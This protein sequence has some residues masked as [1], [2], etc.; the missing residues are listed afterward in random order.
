M[1]T[2]LVI[3][4]KNSILS[5]ML[6]RVS[7]ILRDNL[8]FEQFNQISI[9][10]HFFPDKWDHDIPQRPSNPTLY[11]DLS[12]RDNATR[13]PSGIKR[14]MDIIGSALILVICAPVFLIIALAIKAIVERPGVL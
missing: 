14:M 6:S 7:N 4:D 9:S 11:P 5:T 1:F 13:L 10:F 2:E 12:E 3:D 8:T